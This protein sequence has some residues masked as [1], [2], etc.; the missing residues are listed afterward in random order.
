MA[1]N[2]EANEL[3]R[4]LIQVVARATFPLALV[5]DVVGNKPTHVRAFNLCDGT[6]SQSEIVKKTGIDQGNF[7]RTLQ[8]WID[9]GVVFRVSEEKA[10]LLHVYPIEP[11]AKRGGRAT[12][13]KNVTG[14]NR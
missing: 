6:R 7:S 12:G 1:S 5:R 14:R 8:R 11:K 3:M 13:K 10:T 9:A 4:I 2:E